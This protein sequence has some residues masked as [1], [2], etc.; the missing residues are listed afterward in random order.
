MINV[1]IDYV[2]KINNNKLNRN[3]IETIAGQW[4]RLN[5]R[6]VEEAMKQAE[7]E[8]KEYKKR[9]SSK[10]IKIN[11]VEKLPEWFDKEIEEEAL[12]ND[13]KNKIENMLKD[14]S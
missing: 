5:V 4:K 12:S 10:T 6:T 14:F 9:I 1:L 13:E 3:F 8:H 11:K 2:L 7:K